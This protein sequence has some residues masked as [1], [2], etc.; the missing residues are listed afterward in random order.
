MGKTTRDPINVLMVEDDP[1]YAAAVKQVLLRS[2]HASFTV[3]HATSSE[4]C[5][6]LL[7]KTPVPH[8]VLVDYWLPDT[9]GVTVAKELMEKK[10]EAPIVLLTSNRDFATAVDALKVGL[11]DYLVKDQLPMSMIPRTLIN[12]RERYELRRR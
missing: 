2:T 6:H 9:T 10:V 11:F 8:L 4:E 3:T 1:A 5:F 7:S 12:L